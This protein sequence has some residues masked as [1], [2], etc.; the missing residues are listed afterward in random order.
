[1][2]YALVEFITGFINKFNRE[3]IIGCIGR[4]ESHDTQKMR[5]DV[6]PLLQYT[7]SGKSTSQDYKILPDIPVLFLYAGGFY[8]RP[9]YKKGD[10]VWVT[11]ATHE[12]RQGLNGRPDSTSGRLFS[13][14]NAAVEHGIAKTGWTAPSEFSESGLLLGHEDGDLYFQITKD[15]VKVKGDFE[16]DGDLKTTGKIETDDDIAAKG[17]I[18]ADQEVSAM[19]ATAGVNLSTHIHPYVDTPAGSSNTS[20][21]TPGT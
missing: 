12:I 10:L 16:I 5:A 9:E 8:I 1:M 17:K 14:E 21:P 15:K 3:M 11:F 13:M 6:K 4:I 20:S 19:K 7:T 2:T 18:E